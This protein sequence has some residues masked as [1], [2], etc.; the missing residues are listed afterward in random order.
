MTEAEFAVLVRRAGLLAL[1]ANLDAG[2]IGAAQFE[3][4][5]RESRPSVTPEMEREYEALRSQLKQQGPTT[6]RSRIGF[7]IGSS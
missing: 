7:D 1:R 3:H 6:P 5:L 4:A 2:V